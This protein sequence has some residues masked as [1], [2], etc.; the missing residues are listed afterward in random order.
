[1]QLALTSSELL[2]H[3]KQM[4][5]EA[6]ELTVQDFPEKRDWFNAPP[7]S[8]KKELLSKL[9][10]LDFWTFSCI[11]SIHMLSKLDELKKKYAKVPVAFIGVHS[12]KFDNE[13]NSKNISQA[14]IRYGIKHPVINDFD[15][16]M[17][18]HLNVQS[19]PTLALVGPK[20]NLLFMVSGE[21]RLDDF[22]LAIETALNFY[23]PEKLSAAPLPAHTEKGLPARPSP[24]LFP[25]KLSIDPQGSRLFISDSGHHRIVATSVTGEKLSQIGCGNPGFADGSFHEAKFNHPNG[26]HY[27]SG[28]LYIADTGNHAIREADFAS[29]EVRTIAG[30]G[31]QGTDYKGGGVGA[32]QALCSPWDIALWNQ[33]LF[34]AMAGSHQ[35][36]I[37][38]LE[39]KKSVNFSGSG[40]E[41]NYND[42]NLQH[43]GWAQPSGLYLHDF[44]LF[45]ADSESSAI[46][47]VDLKEMQ[48]ATLVGGERANPRNLFAFGDSEGSDEEGKLQ[49]PLG[50]VWIPYLRQLAIS[51]SYNHRLK[52]FDPVQR[53]L[54][55]WVGSGK[56]GFRDEMAKDALFS[57]PSGLALSPNGKE[58][59]VADTNNHAIRIVNIDTQRVKTLKFTGF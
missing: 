6:S 15:M 50:V 39:S 48:V 10:I 7:L 41:L 52:L 5:S 35:I 21:D 24:F 33:F 11:H 34:I 59:F 57:E 20:G 31:T 1:M 14:V 49:H 17:W 32:S 54:Y 55:N 29:K 56:P 40:A 45:I 26:I 23:T 43:C 28:K 47:M 58:V 53:Q 22:N 44:K 4:D 30:N 19:W 37:H 16:T 12:P 27:A 25:S 9:V 38:D 3:I 36:W 8:F 13:K 42:I 46:R 18:R 51:D 2:T